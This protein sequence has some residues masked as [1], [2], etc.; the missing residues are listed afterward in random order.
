MTTLSPLS[1]PVPGGFRWIITPEERAHIG[2]LL[3][4]HGSDISRPAT[5]M[6]QDHKICTGCG[7]HS[8]L[9][10]LIQNALSLGIHSASFMLD[11]LQNGPKK[12]SPAHELF[13]SRCGVKHSE[14]FLWIPS[15][16]WL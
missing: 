7:K 10:D 5:L 12:D 2:S 3:D 13:C 11:V 6:V 15:N 16:P 4:C 14:M 8:G 1:E 9:D